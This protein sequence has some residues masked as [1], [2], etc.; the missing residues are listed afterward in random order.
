[1][2]VGLKPDEFI[3]NA[4]RHFRAKFASE[5]EKYGIQAVVD[6]FVEGTPSHPPNLLELWESLSRESMLSFLCRRD[7]DNPNVY[8]VI[9]S[10][11]PVTDPVGLYKLWYL[12]EFLMDDEPTIGEKIE[13][14][15]I[16]D[17]SYRIPIFEG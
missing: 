10:Q 5:R 7:P 8:F 12:K 17:K 3:V 1:M 11:A 16:H 4:T 15:K 14:I 6:Q 13:C 9:M 2:E